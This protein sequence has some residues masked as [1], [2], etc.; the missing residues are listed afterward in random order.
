MI[1]LQTQTQSV[2]RELAR[3]LRVTTLAW[4]LPEAG[5]SQARACKL[6]PRPAIIQRMACQNNGSRVSAGPFAPMWRA[7]IECFD[8]DGARSAADTKPSARFP[9][10]SRSVPHKHFTA[11]QHD[12]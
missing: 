9:D 6:T 3:V 2:Q 4:G 8:R 5:P 1:V 10:N 11:D 12:G 7:L